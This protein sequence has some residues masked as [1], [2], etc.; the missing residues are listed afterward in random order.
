MYGAGFVKLV[1]LCLKSWEIWLRLAP[2]LDHWQ[3]I[4]V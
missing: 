1:V 3:R 2:Y 4:M